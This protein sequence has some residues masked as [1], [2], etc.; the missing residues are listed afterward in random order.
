M[1]FSQHEKE[2]VA[3]DYFSGHLGT[4]ATRT[5]TID[6]QALGY[7]TSVGSRT[8]ARGGE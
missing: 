7:K 3:Y 5:M 4:A 1:V 2:K 8:P 6:W